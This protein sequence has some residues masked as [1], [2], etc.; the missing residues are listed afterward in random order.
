MFDQDDDETSTGG[1]W[2]SVTDLFITLFI[3]SIV[4]LGAVF[5]VLLPKNNIA[6]NEIITAVGKDFVNVKEPTNLLRKELDLPPITSSK[7]G[8]II[9]DLKET[10]TVAVERLQI[11]K[12]N[13]PTGMPATIKSLEEKIKELED[14]VKKLQEQLKETPR[15]ENLAELKRK[16]EQLEKENRELKKENRELKKDNTNIVIAENRPEFK[17]DPGSPIISSKFSSA[18]R[19]R[20]P[21]GEG[22]FNEPPFP[23]IA[24]EIIS[25]QERVDTLEVIGHTDGV[26]LSTSG[27][28]D[29]R[30]PDLL[31][32]ELGDPRRLSAGSNNDLGLLRA[33]ALKQEWGN[34]VDTYEPSADRE[35]LQR[36][37]LRC[38]SAGQTILPVQE[39]NPRPDSFR[40][41][42]PSAR[43]IEMRLTRLGKVADA[44]E[45]GQ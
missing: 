18:L 20:I 12:K 13:Y 4:M 5:Y 25:R 23:R 8:Q 39:A 32:G 38:Y 45:G 10:C 31:A 14:L 36:V 33:L 9:R 24:A 35:V 16:I 15:P 28:L 43:R 6:G 27:N 1:Y 21:N 22:G 41:N 19:V 40:R 42:D 30:L 11:L 3:I 17:F 29:Q 37:N 7:A 2:P 44:N 26:P 34:Y